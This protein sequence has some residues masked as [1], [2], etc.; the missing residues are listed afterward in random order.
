MLNDGDPNQSR[1]ALF[2][3]TVVVTMD[4]FQVD[5]EELP[6]GD[7]DLTEIGEK[8]LNLVWTDAWW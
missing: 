6:G 4:P 1:L 2:E 3:K 7:R 8:G 5:L